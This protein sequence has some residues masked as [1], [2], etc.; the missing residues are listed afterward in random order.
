MSSGLEKIVQSIEE[1]AESEAEE[2]LKEAKEKAE[3]KKSQGEEKAERKKARIIEKG[4]SRAD[5]IEKRII[6]NARR[7]A[8]QDKLEAREEIIENVFEKAKD[9]LSKLR[10][11]EV[12]EETLRSLIINAGKTV[13]G[14]ELEVSVLEGDKKR[15]TDKENISKK[16]EKETDKK[17][18]IEIKEGLKNGMGGALVSRK[19]GRVACDNTLKTRLE[20]KKD[21]LRTQIAEKLFEE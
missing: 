1:K 13:G 15:I 3:E 2:I 16:I 17:T 18:S 20:R 6:A 9:R 11:E 19:D 10:E 7:E 12:Y 21:E 14:G 8:R 4:K 5:T